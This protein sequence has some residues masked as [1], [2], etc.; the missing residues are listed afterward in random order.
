MSKKKDIAPDYSDFNSKMTSL[1]NDLVQEQIK[2]KTLETK[3]KELE[4]GA[5]LLTNE[6]QTKAVE[7]TNLK[8]EKEKL[9]QNISE[10]NEKIQVDKKEIDEL[11]LIRK[12]HE[13]QNFEAILQEKNKLEKERQE[14]EQQYL[15]MKK[16]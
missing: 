6:I 4:E 11:R 2:N 8:N 5:K 15:E 16:K 3:N 12:V 9:T 10:L 1:I 14:I 7:I 13:E